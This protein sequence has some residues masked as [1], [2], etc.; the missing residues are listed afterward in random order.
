VLQDAQAMQNA[1]R[2]LIRAT[3]DNQLDVAAGK[4]K[5]AY[6]LVLEEYKLT[7]CNRPEQLVLLDDPG[8]FP[9]QGL[10]PMPFDFDSQMTNSDRST[11][12]MMSI[13]GRS[14]SVSS[15]HAASALDLNFGSSSGYSVYQLP[16][17]DVFGKSPL[18]KNDGGLG[19]EEVEQWV[20]EE[21][22]F[23]FDGDGNLIEGS[24]EKD[25][26]GFD[27][28]TG[29]HRPSDSAASTRVRKEHGEGPADPFIAGDDDYIMQMG[30]DDMG[31]LQD[32]GKPLGAS[33]LMTGGLGGNDQ[34]QR[35]A[36]EDLVFSEED[37]SSDSAQAPL[38]KKKK[39]RA[40]KKLILDKELALKNHDLRTW[41]VNY[42][43]KMKASARVKDHLRAN[44]Q[45][46]NNAV[47][48]VYGSGLSSVG[49]GIGFDKFESPLAMF[50]GAS[51][52]SLVTGRAPIEEEKKGRKRKGDKLPTP[53]PK[54]L[55]SERGRGS[56]REEMQ[57]FGDG[58]GIILGDDDQSISVEM[59]RDAASALQDYPSSALMP[60]NK[61]ATLNPRQRDLSSQ[62]GRD[63]QFGSGLGASARLPS[64]S[65]L[66]GRGSAVAKDLSQLMPLDDEPGFDGENDLL[67][68]GGAGDGRSSSGRNSVLRSQMS[69]SQQDE[70]EIYG[71]AANVDT[72]TAGSSQWLREA[73]DKESNNFFDYVK[74]TIEEKQHDENPMEEVEDHITFEELFNVKDNSHIVA[75]QAFYHVL[76]LATKRKVWV[77]Q[78]MGGENGDEEGQETGMVP[79]G[80]IRIGVVDAF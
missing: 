1:I 58:D 7:S 2:G 22:L 5:Y 14:G 24:A 17:H 49:D 70:F 36:T 41:Q 62:H 51:L 68:F 57:Q 71:Q 29:T 9:E 44:A 26:F 72:Q 76:C 35:H 8:F 45:A 13:R 56:P 23:G 11:Q 10:P 25:P 74:N 20:E 3:R 21:Q 15:H 50:S 59:G 40:K 34:P 30:E 60:W 75:A 54:R 52:L 48:F 4:A 61:S 73:L 37:L 80:E 32:D 12:S 28:I 66:F 55:E 39:P 77:E 46:K 63:T 6:S 43:E 64:A 18:R 19:R 42:S 53:E 27:A 78:D 79:F 65:P 33:L 16:H 47:H 38:T 67:D 31:M 69:R